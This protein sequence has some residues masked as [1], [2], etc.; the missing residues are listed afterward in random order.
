MFFNRSFFLLVE[1]LQMGAGD[2]GAWN[3]E[4]KIMVMIVS[5]IFS[6]QAGEREK[7]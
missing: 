1:M 6:V 4:K 5:S 3:K 2:G 7:I